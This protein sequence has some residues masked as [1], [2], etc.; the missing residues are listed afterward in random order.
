M[1]PA[2]IYKYLLFFCLNW[3]FHAISQAQNDYYQVTGEEVIEF[4]CWTYEYHIETNVHLIS[5][6]WQING[7]L[8]GGSLYNTSLEFTYPG[9][10]VIMAYSIDSLGQDY[11]DELIVIVLDNS[12][13]NY[14]LTGCYEYNEISDCYKVCAFSNTTIHGPLLQGE[15]FIEGALKYTTNDFDEI[16]ITWGAGGAGEV[17]I[18]YD[19][20]Y[21]WCFEIL[22]EPVSDFIASTPIVNDT[23][24]VCKNEEIQ[25]LNHSIN[26]LEY[27]WDFGDGAVSQEYNALHAFSEEGFYTVSLIVKSI[28][29]CIST[30]TIVVKVLPSPVPTLDCVNSVCPGMRQRYNAST[31]ECTQFNWTV[32]SNGDIVNGGGVSD[33]F[34]EIIWDEG[35]DGIIELAVEGCSSEY[36]SNIT[37]FRV[38]ILTTDGPIKGDQNVCPGE[39]TKY[40]VPYFPG[41]EYLWNVGSI[42]T[43]LGDPTKNSITVQWPDG[44][45]NS[46]TKISVQYNNCFLDCGGEDEIEVLLRPAFYLDG[47]SY[48]CRNGTVTVEAKGNLI[49]S[50]DAIWHLENESGDTIFISP[51]VTSQITHTYTYPAG[52]YRWIATNPEMEYCNESAS[53]DIQIVET[54]PP[55]LGIL[56]ET[57]ICP[58]L[59]TGFTIVPAGIYT[60]L[61]DITDGAN[62]F[63]STGQSCS[64]H[65]GEFPP[66]SVEAVHADI[67]FPQCT[68]PPVLVNLQPIENL[69]IEGAADVCVFNI[70]MYS[71]E[72]TSGVE[73]S[74]E[75]IPSDHGQIQKTDL[76]QIEIFWTKPGQVNL[77]LRACGFVYNK[78]IEIHQL[79]E[80]KIIGPLA[81]CENEPV[82]LTTDQPG[83][84]HVWMDQDLNILGTTNNVEL[85]AGTYA[86][87]IQNE[88][89][90]EHKE[91]FSINNYPTP[92]V[93]ISSTAQDNY[94]TTIPGGV[95]I[96]ANT[97]GS[98]YQFEW[99]QN[100]IST[101]ATGPAFNV[102][103]FGGY[104]VQVTN[105]HGCKAVTPE[106]SFINCCPPDTCSGPVDGLPGGCTCLPYDFDIKMS[107]I[108]CHLHRYELQ[109]PNV[110]PN[111]TYW[112]IKNS[113]EG[114]IAIVNAEVL[115]YSYSRPGYYFITPVSKIAGYPY[116]LNIC[117]HLQHYIDTIRAVADF[118]YLGT[119]AGEAIAFTDLT[120]FLPQEEIVSWEWNFDDP[121]S[122]LNNS[123]GLQDP[124]HIFSNAGNFNVHLKVTLKS[125]CTTSVIKTVQ[126]TGGPVLQPIFENIHCES[127]AVSFFLP[128]DHFDISWDFGDP[129]SGLLN[130]TN[131]DSALHVYEDPGVYTIQVAAKDIFQCYSAESFNIDIRPNILGGLI[132][133]DPGS[134]ICY[135][136]TV[137][138]T[139]PP[140]GIN[141]H[142]S[143]EE[144]TPEIQVAESGQYQ[145]VLRDLFNCSYSPPP[146]FINVQPKPELI[147]KAREILGEGKY[148]PWAETLKVCWGSEFQVQ[149]FVNSN[150]SYEWSTGSND[151]TIH[152]TNEGGNLLSPGIHTLTLEVQSY[153]THCVNQSSITIEVFP[154][155]ATPSISLASGS[156]CGNDNNMLIV[157]NPEADA[158]YVWS[159]GQTGIS[160]NG[161]GS[162]NY[163]VT[164]FTPNGCSAES[165]IIT[166][167][168]SAPA[169]QIP[170]GCYLRCDPLNVCLPDLNDVASY[171]IFKNDTLF[172]SGSVWPENFFITEDGT[173]VIEIIS[174]NGCKSTSDPLNILLYPGIGN[175]T[176]QTYLD[177][178]GNGIISS[179]DVLL[180]GIP[181]QIRSVDDLY[182]G[183]A[184]S[185]EEGHY[186][187]KDFPAAEYIAF[188]DRALLSSQWKVVIDSTHTSITTCG[189]SLVV[190]LLLRENCVAFGE[191]QYFE[192]CPGEF[193]TLGDSTWADTGV[194]AMHI[195]SVTG[196][197]S[198]YQIFI[199]FPDSIQIFGAVWVDVD[200]NGILSPADTT[201]SGIQIVIDNNNG[202]TQF[203][204]TDGNGSI[205]GW[206]KDGEYYISVDSAMLPNGFIPLG[207]AV[208]LSDTVCGTGFF[209]FLLSP[210]CSDVIII[211]YMDLCKGDSALIEGNWISEAGF[212]SFSVNQSASEC[213]SILDA[214]IS[215]YPDLNLYSQIEWH[216]LDLGSIAIVPEG[217]PPFTFEWGNGIA[218]DSVLT[219]LPASSYI[220][221][222]TDNN[223]CE[224][225]DTLDIVEPE[226]GEFSIQN[227]YEVTAGDSVEIQIEGDILNP[228]L[229]YQWWPA[230]I[231]KCDTCQNTYATPTVNTTVFIQIIDGYG[232]E[233]LLHTELIIIENNSE[234]RDTFYIPNVFTPDGNGSNDN[235]LIY[236]RLPDT[237]L[238]ELSIFDRWGSLLYLV[239]DIPVSDMKGWDGTFGGVVMNPQVFTYKATIRYADGEKKI[240]YGTVTLVK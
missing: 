113:S 152:F 97:D 237:H 65:F 135:G 84:P 68:S 212:Y 94:C 7:A 176:V 166:I 11:F 25:F 109:D 99:F 191:D 118:E 67:Q 216:C 71:V 148:G 58:D 178:D 181:I 105:E 140:G 134:E 214:Y 9:T 132:A 123:S 48:V 206:F 83:L 139:S 227:Y 218:G 3:S 197:D 158:L 211:Q 171:S 51:V 28:C 205:A 186:V 52:M 142:W 10:Y 43:I 108:E 187:F 66:Y 225:I 36:C 174:T 240:V 20:V 110:I 102:T 2:K 130:F 235:F 154:L 45:F 220:V 189:D 192:L 162:G 222:I 50:E 33:D 116:D 95:E 5:T 121:S 64:V 200:R 196:C 73:Y 193:L 217:S 204:T 63:S 151:K 136:D 90:C 238:E 88:F 156:G 30:R 177:V 29:S 120:T 221:T 82:F 173:Y 53:W 203:A 12:S 49:S 69:L 85:S 46:T 160:I 100:N 15:I 138:L 124:E 40:E 209:H 219:N 19:C 101:G 213:D 72:F 21:Q 180:P 147:I 119:C 201:I 18:Y 229:N 170:G 195:S 76:N 133:I 226:A 236:S 234:L 41:T 146:V 103:D 31:E 13:Q 104:H 231:L 111:E 153:I 127:E 17:K 190:K 62:S 161:Q 32:S 42:G 81:A 8:L 47:N 117:R 150:V 74:W 6:E 57:E 34:I 55:P 228:D 145:L 137:E 155:P 24:T 163:Y 202:Q 56:G 141:W 164:A 175:I 168:P 89:G 223:G 165:N 185:G 23:I 182:A 233:Y 70:D 22:P 59:E 224:V 144:T 159:N 167:K 122:G 232:C 210:N 208:H 80:F 4:P 106:I 37:S 128:G 129:G 54:P 149:G 79:P 77:K 60:T 114:T 188:I 239:R 172:D 75:L 157:T 126:V 87:R 107:E 112:I 16:N 125:G 38:P 98:G 179:S 92:N 131:A 27:T 183:I 61:W 93:I 230:E 39:T 115:E 194:Y 199:A 143:T 184:E 26:G 96:V 1:K 198:Q 44:N 215:N 14:Y 35:P 207:G 91:S 86:V 169:D 78:T